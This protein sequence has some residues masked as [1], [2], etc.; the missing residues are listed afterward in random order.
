L[1]NEK[2]KRSWSF[3]R[4][5][6]EIPMDVSDL[7]DL[8]SIE[9]C[10]NLLGVH[11]VTFWRKKPLLQERGVKFIVTWTN[12]RGVRIDRDSLLAY[13]DERMLEMDGQS[14]NEW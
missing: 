8:L 4:K 13:L 12:G 11:R 1:G 7:P 10:C 9:Q 5:K 2:N 14:A 3:H 6:P